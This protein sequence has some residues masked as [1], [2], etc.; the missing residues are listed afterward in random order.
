MEPIYNYYTS[1]QFYTLLIIA[2]LVFT[3]LKTNLPVTLVKILFLLINY[4]FLFLLAPHSYLL[5]IIFLYSSSVWALGH[6]VKKKK[7]TTISLLLVILVLIVHKYLLV[8]ESTATNVIIKS[9]F[10]FQAMEWIGLSYVTIRSIDY[11]LSI[12]NKKITNFDYLTSQNYLTFFCFYI[13]G[14]IERFRN[15]APQFNT[16][17]SISFQDA[18][19]AVLRICFG[20]TKILFFSKIFFQYSVLNA[21]YLQFTHWYEVL[22][23]LYAYFL[24]IYFDFSGY[25]DCAIGTAKLFG[26]KLTE[27]FNYPFI[28]T[29]IQDFW[30]RW[31]ISLSQWC[32]DHIFFSFSKFL[33]KKFTNISMIYFSIFSMFVTFVILG[34]W[35]GAGLNW[36]CYGMYHGAGLSLFMAY[37]HFMLSSFEA[38][39]EK[40]QM[41]IPYRVAM[42]IFTFNFVALGL[43]FSLSPAQI[44][45]LWN[46]L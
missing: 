29:S 18:R 7:T 9:I 4:A 34:I 42:G 39:Y 43:I 17:S 3:L 21:N 24:Y 2:T 35:H 15:M 6:L 30:N 25:C 46:V 14:P 36:V 12:N 23:G 28:A 10:A 45:L 40:M 11:I 38:I 26:I 19:S 31:H 22:F 44:K 20:I 41:F 33:T 8:P 1:L 32:R 13:S 37:R 16:I 5:P 27:N